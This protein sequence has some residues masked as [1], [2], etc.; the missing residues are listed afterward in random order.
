MRE[1]KEKSRSNLETVYEVYEDGELIGHE[2]EYVAGGPLEHLILLDQEAVGVSKK[3][4]VYTAG[5]GA[6]AGALVGVIATL[7]IH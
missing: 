1:L 6:L 3:A 2:I 4:T 5:L 7:V